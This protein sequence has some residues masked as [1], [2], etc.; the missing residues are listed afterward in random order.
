MGGGETSLW[1]SRE[2]S[3]E[4]AAE[5]FS[6]HHLERLMGLAA[7]VTGDGVVKTVLVVRKSGR[8]KRR[9]RRGAK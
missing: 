7:V 9:Y 4:L 3:Q 1:L 2:A 6:P 8:G 5:G